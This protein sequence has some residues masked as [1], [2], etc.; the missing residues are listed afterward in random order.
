MKKRL[1]LN[2]LKVKSFVTNLESQN[3]RGGLRWESAPSCPDECPSDIMTDPCTIILECATTIDD[4]ESYYYPT[5]CVWYC[6]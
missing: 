5:N 1:S 3:V 4:C 2:Q 6:N